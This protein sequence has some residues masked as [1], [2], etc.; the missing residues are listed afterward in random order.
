MNIIKCF[1]GWILIASLENI[2]LMYE[3]LN[4]K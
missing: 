1:I 4:L 3:I 2:V